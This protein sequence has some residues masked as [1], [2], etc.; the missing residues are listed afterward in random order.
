M[1]GEGTDNV[2]VDQLD[3]DL[4]FILIDKAKAKSDILQRIT[5]LKGHGGVRMYAEVYK[6]FTET[7]GQGLMEQMQAM[8]DPKPA[9]K[10]EETAEAI[11]AWEEKMNRLARYGE[12]YKLP[13]T[14]KKVALKKILIGKIRDHFELW[15]FESPKPT[16]ETLLKRVKDQARSKKLDR[17]VQRG[18]TGV[19]LGANQ[20]NTQQWQEPAYAHV[21]TQ[22]H[23]V[24][25]T[26]YQPGK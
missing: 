14:G 13:E 26:G 6:W 16:F 22:Q 21:P 10:E 15:E 7:S 25:H 1:R 2:D 24:A 8:M 12:E 4:E 5:N 23:Q 20:A 3:A 11:E 18:R 9:V 19:S 17:D